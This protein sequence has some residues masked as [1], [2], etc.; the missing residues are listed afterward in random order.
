MA[1]TATPSTTASPEPSATPTETGTPGSLSTSLVGSET[2]TS[3]PGSEPCN[4]LFDPGQLASCG[5][6]PGPVG[7]Q[8]CNN[9]QGPTIP[10]GLICPTPTELPTPTPS[11]TPVVYQT[12]VAVTSGSDLPLLPGH[13]GQPPVGVTVSQTGNNLT[14]GIAINT[15][16][17]LDLSHTVDITLDPGVDAS[18][19]TATVGTT[20]VPGSEVQW[21]IASLDSGQTASI[22]ISL[23]TTTGQ[24]TGSVVQSITVA[25]SDQ[26]AGEEVG[27]IASTVATGGTQGSGSDPCCQIRVP[28]GSREILAGWSKLVKAP[29]KGIERILHDLRAVSPIGSQRLPATLARPRA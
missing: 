18:G 19:A 4:N 26:Q 6:L 16:D 23:A 25:G 29:G 24:G 13:E 20:A 21:N 9:G 11:P 10:I 14:I 27:E 12:N 17:S 2:G 3:S 5:A 7:T 8:V 22:S 1:P 28:P 15:L